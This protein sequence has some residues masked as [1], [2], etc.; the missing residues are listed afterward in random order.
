MLALETDLYQLTMAAGY[1]HRGMT[2]ALATCEMFVRRLPARRRYLVAMGLDPFLRYLEGL[3]F[4]EDEIDYLA[5]VPALRDA[6]TPAFV[7]YLRAFRFTGDVWAVPEGTVVFANEP[8]VRV[9]API[10]EAQLVETYL[11]SVVNHATMVASKAARMVQAAGDAGLMEFGTRRTHPS[12][13][14]DAARAACAVG[15][16]GTSNVEAGRRY[17]LPVLGTAAHMWTMAHASEEEAFQGYVAVFP[18][19]STLLIDTYDTLHGAACAARVAVDKL[20]GVRLDSGDL[21]ALS[22]GVRKILDDAGCKEAKIVASG[23]LNEHKIAD[24]RRARAPIDV[25]GVG[26]ELVASVD[27]PALGGVYK[28]VELVRAGKTTPIA[29]FSEDKATYPGVHQ[30]WRYRDETGASARDVLALEAELP[31]GARDGS[32]AARALLHPAMTHGMRVDPPEP[33]DAIRAR[34]RQEL[35]SL[36]PGLHGLDVGGASYAVTPSDRLVALVEEV[37]ARLAPG[38]KRRP[39]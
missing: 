33:L 19:A 24:L 23:D 30:I 5:T 14:I 21:D 20:K 36:P 34:V 3:R 15:F 11:L 26:T 17:G 16:I 31:E 35:A 39:S 4:T 32:G 27:A 38:S 18:S 9:T 10:I 8:I 7:D 29:K 1:F 25:Y 6:M 2:D 13:A 28:L 22:R 12:A 37:R